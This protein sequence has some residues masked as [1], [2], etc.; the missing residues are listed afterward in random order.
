MIANSLQR[1]PLAWFFALAFGISWGGILVTEQ[2][3][4]HKKTT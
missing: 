4:F 1:H 2:A 3:P